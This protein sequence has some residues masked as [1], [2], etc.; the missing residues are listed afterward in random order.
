MAAAS[1]G[2]SVLSLKAATHKGD[3][4]P[5]DGNNFQVYNITKKI[6]MSR[7]IEK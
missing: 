4:S 6:Y 1:F 3:L 2:F 7:E 5:G